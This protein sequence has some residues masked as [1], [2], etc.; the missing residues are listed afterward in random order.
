MKDDDEYS[1]LEIVGG[2]I[3]SS[4]EVGNVLDFTNLVVHRWKNVRLIETLKEIWCSFKTLLRENT[5]VMWLITIMF[6][7]KKK[8]REYYT[9]CIVIAIIFFLSMW[10][11]IYKYFFFLCML[12]T[13][14]MPSVPFW[15]LNIW[16]LQQQ[17][18]CPLGSVWVHSAVKLTWLRNNFPSPQKE[19]L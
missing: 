11:Y 7:K 19:L 17:I 10:I 18:Q 3:N 13:K 4:W 12:Y 5:S 8:I 9:V 1:T 2:G 16:Y 15:N 6:K 14:K